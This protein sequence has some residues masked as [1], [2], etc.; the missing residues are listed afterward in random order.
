MRIKPIL[1]DTFIL[2]ILFLGIPAVMAIILK[3]NSVIP[4]LIWFQL[5]LIWAQAEIAMRQQVLFTQQFKPA[6]EVRMDK[7]GS[8]P[9]RHVILSNISSKPAYDLF[10]SRLLR[11]GIDAGIMPVPPRVWKDNIKTFRIATL[12]PGQHRVVCQIDQNFN[13]NGY[14]IEIIYRDQL[15]E[16]ESVH[17][18]FQSDEEVY[19]FQ[20]KREPPG[21]LLNKFETIRLF[22]RLWRGLPKTRVRG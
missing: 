19:L 1:K 18:Q 6:F 12:S 11:G 14:S 17:I 4:I 9:V 5:L 3:H 7:S 16:F 8:P 2:A 22:W 10:V 20:A 21:F 15:G 13:M